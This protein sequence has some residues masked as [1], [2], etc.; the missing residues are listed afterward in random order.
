MIHLSVAFEKV[1]PFT[2]F[3]RKYSLWQ[4]PLAVGN[5]EVGDHSMEIALVPPRAFRCAGQIVSHRTSNEESMF[6][7]FKDPL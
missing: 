4:Y 5:K 1:P 7:S 2:A 6:F 3:V